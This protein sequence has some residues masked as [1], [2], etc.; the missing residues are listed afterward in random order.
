MAIFELDGEAP[1]L[2]ADGRDW[3]PGG[4]IFFGGRGLAGG[5]FFYLGVRPPPPP[6][7]PLGAWA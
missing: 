7:P 5:C 4:A 6:P 1:D 2:P 3:I